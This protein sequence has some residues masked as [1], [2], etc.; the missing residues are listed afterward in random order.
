MSVFLSNLTSLPLFDV[1]LQCHPSARPSLQL[2]VSV[3]SPLTGGLQSVIQIFMTT[4]RMEDPLERFC[5]LAHWA[6]VTEGL[7]EQVQRQNKR[8]KVVSESGE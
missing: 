4:S 7:R 1:P 2:A 6:V 8:E 5:A 3:A